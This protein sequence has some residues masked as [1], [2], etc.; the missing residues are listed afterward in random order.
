MEQT[1]EIHDYISIRNKRIVLE[2]ANRFK[3]VKEAL[4]IFH[5][6]KR[7]FINPGLATVLFSEITN[8]K[9]AGI[10]GL[11]FLLR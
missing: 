10:N 6:P 4:K 1:K 7:H 3:S 8:F 9:K 2:Y 5:V 11:L